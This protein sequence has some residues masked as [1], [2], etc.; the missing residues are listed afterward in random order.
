ML[1]DWSEVYSIGIA[2]IDEQ[3]QG[4]FAASHRLYESIMDLAGKD[5]V[6]E[7]IAF[8]H[9]YAEHHFATEEAFMRQHDYAGLA[10]HLR[11]HRAFMETLNGLEQDLHNFGPSERLADRALDITQ[12]WLINHIADED[13]LYAMDFKF[14]Q[15]TQAPE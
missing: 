14:R 15:A 1:K 2:E 7:A 10:D 13:V 8:M 11:L 9:D 5:A 6:A 3:H 4:F 12:D